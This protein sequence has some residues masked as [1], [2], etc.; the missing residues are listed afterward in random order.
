[1]LRC[2]E[3]GHLDF[4]K[5]R[6]QLERSGFSIAKPGPGAESHQESNRGRKDSSKDSSNTTHRDCPGSSQTE[7]LLIRNL[8]HE[9]H[10]L[11]TAEHEEPE[12]K[13]LE[14]KLVVVGCER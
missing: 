9:F 1:M 12:R 3:T 11:N 7:L 2:F 4:K 14:R 5:Q 8:V 13:V 6:Y 10:L